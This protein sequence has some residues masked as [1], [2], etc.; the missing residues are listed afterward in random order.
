MDLTKELHSKIDNL[1]NQNF[2]ANHQVDK[3]SKTPMS[4]TINM[5]WSQMKQ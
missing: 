1:E 4:H 5:E 2:C 3:C